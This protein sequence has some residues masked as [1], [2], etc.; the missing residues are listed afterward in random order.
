VD[1]SAVES[2]AVSDFVVSASLNS[3]SATRIER[4]VRAR[5]P[6]RLPARYRTLDGRIELA[7]TGFTVNVSS[8]GLLLTCQHEIKPGARMEIQ[9][10]WPS[11]LES[12]IPLQLVTSGRVV[13][14][15]PTVFAVEFAG[16]QFR[17]MRSRPFPKPYNYVQTA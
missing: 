11:L 15:E 17:T 9:V 5:Y 10:D 6:V 2:S 13:R 1:G 14:S 3:V 4:R 7:G 8:G 16:Y 12:T